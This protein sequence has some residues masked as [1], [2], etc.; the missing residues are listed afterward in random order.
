MTLQEIN[1]LSEKEIFNYLDIF[2]S[3]FCKKN[4]KNIFVLGVSG[5]IDS[6]LS[7]YIL[8]KL[9]YK[10]ICLIMPCSGN[11]Y[12]DASL[13]VSKIN[14]SHYEI[15]LANTYN[16]LCSAIIAEN[17]TMP[18]NAMINI[19]PRLRMTTLYTF[20]SIYQGLVVSTSNYSEYYLGYF[21]KNGDGAGDVNF[22]NCFYKS[23]IYR[24]AKYLNIPQKIIDKPPSADLIN[25]INDKNELKISS[26]DVVE[27]YLDGK[28][29]SKEDQSSITNWHKSTEHKRIKMVNMLDFMKKF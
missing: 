21:T 1:L 22:L 27:D 9:N 3:N 4:Q 17:G 25:G 2:L 18:V 14:C 12:D 29:I 16:S 5:G 6:A 11:S 23:T 26:Y 15:N 10:T 8:N 28:L 24:L 7:L 20:A 19:Q 13:V